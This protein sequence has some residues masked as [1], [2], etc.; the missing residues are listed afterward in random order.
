MRVRGKGRSGIDIDVDLVALRDGHKQMLPAVLPPAARRRALGEPVNA[1]LV[2][3]EDVLLQV[4]EPRSAVSYLDRAA[5]EGCGANREAG[6]H[7]AAPV[8][9]SD[10]DERSVAGLTEQGGCDAPSLDAHT[11]D[12]F[13]FEG[14]TE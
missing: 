1:N 6:H 11:R 14:R 8:M 12:G 7:V 9:H 10:K 4:G 2:R 5:P 3:T 13:A